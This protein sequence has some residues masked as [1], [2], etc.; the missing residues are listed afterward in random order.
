MT[1]DEGV[2][3][4]KLQQLV[5]SL[6]MRRFAL[7]A[8]LAVCLASPAIPAR[9]THADESAAQK[10]AREIADARD[11]A[12]AA[13][14]AYFDAQDQLGD[15]TV[16]QQQLSAEVADLQSQV[17]LLQQRVQE[18]AINRFT[19]S[20]AAGSLI[21]SGFD[22]PEEQMQV[23]ALSQVITDTSDTQF[24]E[25]DSL[26]RDM[27][28]KQKQLLRSQKKTEQQ[29]VNMAA[30][31]DESLAQIQ[32]L[33]KVEAQRLKDQAV[34]NA[35][36]AEQKRRSEKVAANATF[37]V[38]QTVN[39]KEVVGSVVAAPSKRGTG[40]GGVTAPVIR[41][42]SSGVDWSGTSWVCP[43]GRANVGF[44][45]SFRPF[46]FVAFW[47]LGIDMI[48]HEGTPLLAVVDG[49]A[50]A[51]SNTLGGLTVFLDGD[52]GVFYYYAHLE[53]YGS[54]G[55]V[56]KGDVV[57][58]MGMTGHAGTYHLH[59]EIHPGGVMQPPI[60]PYETLAAH[61]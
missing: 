19:R 51:R 49:V 50:Q 26:N 2:T 46:S 43:T 56:R 40:A 17:S 15:L 32:H 21:L 29:K 23:Q 37:A 31:R 44:G 14:Q 34:R 16:E 55:R 60:D 57:G 11:Q 1:A 25:Y 4:M 39:G 6:P 24:D 54:L 48:G 42:T 35:L 12:D 30:L 27:Q 58:Y 53:A 5:P 20:N 8:L 33:K 10:A 22:T 13:A 36:E 47:H 3:V 28:A 59:F 38:S 7:V 45:R 9:V 61:C 18:V 41:P 52:D